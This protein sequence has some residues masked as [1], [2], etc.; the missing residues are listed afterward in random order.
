M[1]AR[2]KAKPARRKRT[3]PRAKPAS[4]R[5]SEPGRARLSVGER[6]LWLERLLFGDASSRRFTQDSPVLPDVW[7]RYGMRHLEPDGDRRRTKDA[8]DSID[9]LLTPHRDAPVAVLS[10]ALDARRQAYQAPGDWPSWRDAGPAALA[11]NE[12]NVAV[13]LFLDELVGVAL[14]LSSWWSETMHVVEKEDD[15]D[16]RD[17]AAEL[18]ADPEKLAA[19]LWH[20]SR[21]HGDENAEATTQPALDVALHLVKCLPL[22]WLARVVGT[23][24]EIK[25]R[26]ETQK[27][28]AAA[29]MDALPGDHL[30]TAKSFLAL[31]PQNEKPPARPLLW[32]VSLNRQ[33]SASVVRSVLSVKGDAAR[34]LFKIKTGNLAWAVVDSGI[35][36]DHVAFATDP[37]QSPFSA[38]S[39]RVKETYDF[40]KVRKL[41]QLSPSEDADDPVAEEEA[42]RSLRRRLRSGRHLDWEAL[43]PAL[44]ISHERGHYRRPVNDHGTHVAAILAGKW[45]DR[46]GDDGWAEGMCPELQLYDLRVLDEHGRGEEFAVLAALQFIRFLNRQHDQAVIHGVNASLSMKHDVANFACGRT[47]VCDECDRIVASG[48]VVVAAAGNEGY[49]KFLTPAGDAEGYRAISIT[50]PGNTESVITV[51]AT[52]RG[53]PHNYGVSYF[54]SRGPTGDGRPKPDLVAPGE[55]I[56]APVPDGKFA[57][58]DGTSMAAPHVSGAA[59][60]LMARHHELVGQPQRIKQILCKS[61]TDLQRE[62]YFQGHGLV[63]VLRALQ[64][65]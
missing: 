26:V 65:V 1:A 3:G 42:L 63:D 61:A 52:H 27:G 51:G 7:I 13:R 2:R 37:E 64:S 57:T 40:T 47:P 55:K 8:F 15:E 10:R 9:L 5:L 41:L 38:A 18:L 58:K 50:D 39:S 59:A 25:R 11:Y 49:S 17:L 62:S 22:I 36:A 53:E 24:A 6:R 32:T 31:V 44:Q 14:P 48:V 34:R 60:L 19:C 43:R 12:S 46:D 33:V 16:E 4:P 54:S 45:K 28:D 20:V 29:V 23:L 21:E 35:D 56:T 30:K